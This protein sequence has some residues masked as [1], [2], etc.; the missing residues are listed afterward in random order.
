[1]EKILRALGKEMVDINVVPDLYQ[2]AILRGS[3]EEFEGLPI[4]TLSGSPMY[5]WN[6]IVKRAFD[7]CIGVPALLLSLPVL[8]LIAGL[9]KMTSRGP[10]FYA[11]ERMGFD[12]T[13]FRMVKFR[14]MRDDADINAAYGERPTANDG[15]A[16]LEAQAIRQNDLFLEATR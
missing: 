14:T 5:G 2:Y 6:S 9:V 16:L 8:G 4:I 3:V 10:M 7:L 15:R 11:Q 12:G 13:V 1:M